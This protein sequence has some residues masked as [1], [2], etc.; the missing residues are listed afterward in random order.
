VVP[1]CLFV[2]YFGVTVNV[3]AMQYASL[4]L[5]SEFSKHV[6]NYVTYTWQVKQITNK[7]WRE[8][9]RSYY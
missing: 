5:S 7:P 4:A 9:I 3:N 8:S 1:F 6:Y 2:R